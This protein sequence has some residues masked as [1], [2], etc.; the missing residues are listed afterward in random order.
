LNMEAITLAL[1]RL[2]ECLATE[3]LD[4]VAQAI[5]TTDK[6]PKIRAARGKAN[7][8][9]YSV[10][11]VAKGAGMIM[12]NM[13]TMLCFVLTDLKIGPEDLGNVLNQSVSK[14]FNRITVDGDTSTNDCVLALANGTAGNR[15]LSSKGLEEFQ[16]N[17]ETIMKGLALDIV[18]DGE[19]ATKVVEVVVRG[20]RDKEEALEAARTISNS[21]LV[22]TAFY[23][24]DPNWG[25]I[26]AALGR[27]EIHMDPGD[28]DIWI[29]DIQIVSQGIGM[30]I[31]NEKKAAQ[32]MVEEEFTLTVD[33]NQGTM[34]ESMWTCDLTHDY[35]SIN[36]EYRT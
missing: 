9:A 27:A 5:M 32:V 13:A 18:R 30:G 21:A 11:A 26:M 19:G 6:F 3:G 14:T 16:Q 7:G 2:K 12:P 36:A 8:K 22:K 33:L 31:E 15:D 23:G 28:V 29:N 20:A 17:L 34:E 35:V 10:V 4:K 1:P 25:R 24:E